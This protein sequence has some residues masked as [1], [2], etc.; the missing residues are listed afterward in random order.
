M[1][2]RGVESPQI[3]FL[4]FWFILPIVPTGLG[5]T[6]F[7][8]LVRHAWCGLAYPR[9]VRTTEGDICRQ[10]AENLVGRPDTLQRLSRLSPCPS[11]TFFSL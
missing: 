11:E 9:T 10:S 7:G 6:E 1:S 8:K 4:W 5:P 2:V 3:L